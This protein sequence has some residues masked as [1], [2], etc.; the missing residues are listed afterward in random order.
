MPE[1]TNGRPLGIGI[2]GA[3]GIALSHMAAIRAS[4]TARLVSIC[5]A[6]VERAEQAAH[7]ER[8]KWT[9]SL[10][11]L[12]ADDEIDAVIVCTP[13]ITHEE[14][15]T[16]VL[17]SGRHLLMEKPLAM[18]LA[19]AE[20]LAA[21]ASEKGLALAVG[22][23]HRFS[24]QGLAI[25]AAIDSGAIGTPR[26]VR[27]VMNGGWIWAGWGAWVLDPAISGGHSLHNGVHLMDLANWWLGEEATTVSS[28]GQKVTSPALQI[29]DYLV[30]ELG[31]ASGASALCEVS[32]GERPRS[33]SILEITVVG[34]DGVI[35]RDWDADGIL[36]W[37]DQ[38]FQTWSPNG[39]AD[40]TFSREL[41]SFVR[42]AGDPSLVNPPVADAVHVVELGVASELSLAT[43]ETIRIGA[44]A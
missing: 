43:G 11:D 39:A 13:N 17:D 3:G 22:H 32:R 9:G 8:C 26:F 4:T 29:H 2:V 16:K 34:S 28:R 35:T 33:A 18:T 31:Y 7:L 27:I 36:A 30:T 24:D 40:R 42:A 10:D 6:A 21:K 19:G 1:Y 5:D 20:M 41:E 37:F 23:S 25:K 12:L 14:L 38:T 15:G 44:A